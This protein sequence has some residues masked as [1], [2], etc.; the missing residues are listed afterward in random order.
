MCQRLGVN[1]FSR[2]GI[3]R[4]NQ[5]EGHFKAKTKGGNHNAWR[6]Q[7]DSKYDFVAQMDMDYAPNPD[8]LERTLGYFRDPKVAFVGSP[9]IYGNQNENFISKGSAEQAFI[10]YG[11][12]QMGLYGKGMQLFIGANHVYRTDALNDIGGYSG[13]IVED[14]LTGMHL[15]ANG[16]K[17]VYVPEV[18]CIGEGPADWSAYLSQQMRWAYGLIDILFRHTPK[19]L[20]NLSGS[21]KTGYFFLQTFY[22]FGLAQL[23]GVLLILFYLALGWQAASMNFAEWVINSFPPFVLS[24]VVFRWLQRFYINSEEESGWHLRGAFLMFGAWPIYLW[25]FISAVVGRR[26]P[27]A[28]TPKGSAA[29]AGAAG[30]MLSQFSV[31]IALLGVS[32]VALVIFPFTGNNAPHLV[33]W[34]AVNTVSLG[35]IVFSH[36]RLWSSIS[37]QS[38]RWASKSLVNGAFTAVSAFSI[39]AVVASVFLFFATYRQVPG[40]FALGNIS[41]IEIFSSN[42]ESVG[43][44]ETMAADNAAPLVLAVNVQQTSGPTR[45]QLGPKEGQVAVVR[46]DPSNRTADSVMA[47]VLDEH[48]NGVAFGVY[49]PYGSWG[50]FGR[51]VH[52]FVQWESGSVDRI[53]RII[54]SASAQD[55]VAMISWEPRTSSVTTEISH[56]R[57]FALLE[58]IGNGEYDSYIRSVARLVRDMDEDIIMRFA[59]EMDLPND[60]LHPWAG[61]P[62]ELFISAHRRVVDLFRDEGA[63]RVYWLWSPGGYF[64]GA[65]GFVSGDWYPGGEYVDLTGFTALLYWRWEEWDAYRAQNHLFRTPEELIGPRYRALVAYGK[66]IIVPE[67]GIDLHSSRKSEEIPWLLDFLSVV[68]SDFPDIQGLVYFN[69]VHN[70]PNYDADWRLSLEKITALAQVIGSDPYFDIGISSN[71]LFD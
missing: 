21:Q 37:L 25:A 30:M 54:E 43:N 32:A 51:I 35:A 7:N 11:P 13:H 45:A 61:Q 3:P 20:P 1:H 70:L 66:P 15:Y 36:A 16:W 24:M 27:Y 31:H 5:P 68:K 47:T 71:E 64:D 49:D 42:S 52:K 23:L 50:G 33:F 34:A 8:Y 39:V 53:R 22:F 12:M 26:L 55:K 44:G 67:I 46:G 65:G 18:L 9:Q 48:D 57:D 58:R 60:G 19:L 29:Q 69:T 14:H 10:F 4:Y 40:A 28:V 62:P 63:D 41:G 59:H 17:S 6:D 56:E 38:R 2:K